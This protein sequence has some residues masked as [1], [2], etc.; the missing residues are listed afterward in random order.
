MLSIHLI[1]LY[2]AT[3]LFMYDKVAAIQ[4]DMVHVAMYLMLIS[5]RLHANCSAV[6]LCVEENTV[7]CYSLLPSFSLA[8]YMYVVLLQWQKM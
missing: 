8:I 2:V 4:S 1:G 5:N 6:L 3:M 7:R